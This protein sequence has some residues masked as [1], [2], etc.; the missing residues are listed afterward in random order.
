[1]CPTAAE[2]Y[3]EAFAAKLAPAMPDRAKRQ[4]LLAAGM[5]PAMAIGALVGDDLVGLAGFHDQNGSLTSSITFGLLRQHLGLVGAL[6]A[7][8]VLAF[9]ERSP[10]PDELLMDG[11]VVSADH[12]GQGIGS[13]LFAELESYCRDQSLTSIRLD[14]VDNNP[15]ARRLYE[16]LGFEATRTV[17]T[18][19]L[20]RVMGF[21]GATTMVKTLS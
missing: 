8:L 15:G 13:K 3:D 2:L 12:R 6:R 16:R 10:E 14:V 20:R 9:L 7:A 19:Y 5:N 1:M 21:G 11:I 18:P 4:A 17:R